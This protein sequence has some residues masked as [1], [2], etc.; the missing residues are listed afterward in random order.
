LPGK[1]RGQKRGS[2]TWTSDNLQEALDR[3]IGAISAITRGV[4][5]L[6]NDY[7]IEPKQILPLISVSKNAIPLSVFLSDSPLE[8]IVRYLRDSEGMNLQEIAE[9]LGRAYTTISSTYAQSIKKKPAGVY[10][11]KDR[12]GINFPLEIF[13]KK[14]LSAL[15]SA[16]L[17]L[18]QKYQLSVR[19]VGLLLNRNER[20]IWTVLHR[21]EVKMR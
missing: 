15:E 1:L 12:L 13:H 17:Y 14:K 21:A 11:Q 8:G 5:A 16:A 6:N 20:T 9:S 4:I 18:K 3:K 2:N 19:E 7:G 10:K